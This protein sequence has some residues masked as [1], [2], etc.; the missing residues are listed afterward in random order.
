MVYDKLDVVGDV[1]GQFEKLRALLTMLGYRERD[2]AYRHPAGRV[3]VFVGDL[4]DR[5]P[6]QLAV[7][8]TVRRMADAGSALVLLGNHEWNA[9]GFVT[10]QPGSKSGRTV[11]P[12]SK[13]NLSQHGEFLTQVGE[14]SASHIECLDWFRTLPPMLDLGGLRIVHAWWSQEHVDHIRA[15][16]GKQG[17]DEAFVI[18][19]HRPGAPTKAAMDALTKGLEL[20][21]PEGASYV[22]AEGYRHDKIRVAWWRHDA[23][24]YR[25]AAIV[26]RDQMQ[27]VPDTT[28]PAWYPLPPIEGSPILTGHYW[29]TGKPT[30]ESAK[31]A[32]LDYSAAKNGPLVAYRW[33]GETELTNDHFVMVAA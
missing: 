14:G 21:M 29:F 25:E 15:T 26:P 17:L 7:I 4:I 8:K 30:I 32:V 19:G 9:L 12:R 3:A 18:E 24:T 1:H 31:L 13:K 33:D 5:G 27:A 6:D 20:Q 11:R 10:K 23:R 16:L 2:G 22:T 28:L